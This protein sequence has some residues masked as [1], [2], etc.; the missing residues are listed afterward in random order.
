M[1]E[2]AANKEEQQKCRTEGTSRNADTAGGDTDTLP[3]D[4]ATP[5][6]ASRLDTLANASMDV[7]NVPARPF[8]PITNNIMFGMVLKRHPRVCKMLLETI[9]K[10]KL[11]EINVIIREED[12]TGP[13]DAKSV[14]LDVS[15]KAKDRIFNIE[16]QMA[17]DKDIL[18]RM[19]YYQGMIDT[20]SLK[21]GED[22]NKLPNTYIIF[23][24]S[25][26]V[27]GDSQAL[28]EL[29]I[30]RKDKR[31]FFYERM[32]WLIFNFN[33]WD[34]YPSK[35]GKIKE[36]LRYLSTQKPSTDTL[37][38]ELDTIV[39]EL[40]HDQRLVNK[41]V[42]LAQDT[43]WKIERAKDGWLKE[44]RRAEAHAISALHTALQQRN[45]LDD[46][47][48]ALQDDHYREALYKEFGI[49]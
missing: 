15:V 19:S 41:M 13:I 33:D 48:H 1:Q 21:K 4:T 43:Q 29:G 30:S 35:T 9:L 47:Q 39:H 10:I 6:Q 14:R 27:F 17:P 28:Y 7:S 32:H 42:T 46:F 38:S 31:G 20:S 24:C 44:G 12:I 18:H 36:L 37:V 23:F 34:K 26:D 2:D 45:R 5:Y 8:Y 49:S 40:N 22:Y 11:D 3:K 25:W 16:L